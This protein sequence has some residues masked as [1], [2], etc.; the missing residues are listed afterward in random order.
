MLRFYL[1]SILSFSAILANDFY[2]GDTDVKEGVYA[3]YNYDFE[4]AVNILTKARKDFPEHPGVHLIWAAAR[5]VK[6]QSNL[7]V[8]ETYNRLEA[9]LK[10]I[11]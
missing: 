9:D 6:A 2:E 8:E 7:T 11:E 10:E 5:W 4:Q 1:F 3:F